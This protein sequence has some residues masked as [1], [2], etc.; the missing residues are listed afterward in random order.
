MVICHFG[1][2]AEMVAVPAQYVLPIADD[3]SF[4]Q[5]ACFPWNYLVAYHL[6]FRVAR[7]RL[8]ERV[9]VHMAAGGVGLAAVQLLRTI[10]DTTTFGTASSSKHDVLRAEGCQHAIDYRSFDYVNE[11][12]K[13]THGQGVDAALL[14]IRPDRNEPLRCGRE[15]W[16]IL[17]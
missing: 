11:V 13:L 14:A 15:H 2:Q 5:A 10:P 1:A 12:K 6:V 4:E 3:W 17:E 9:L 7:V 16:P 8:G